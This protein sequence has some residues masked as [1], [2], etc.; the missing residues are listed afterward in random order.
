[1]EFNF[2]EKMK[3]L[4]KKRDLTQE[5]L[6]EYFGVSFQA[7]SK[8]ETNAA[9]PDISLIPIIANFYGVTADEL[10]GVNITKAKKKKE[11]YIQ[12]C[13]D[14]QHEWKLLEAVELARKAC[15]EFPGDLELLENLS[16]WLHQ[17][18]GIT[19]SFLNEAIEISNTILTEST[20]TMIRNTATLRLCYCYNDK[21][22]KGKALE[23]ARQLP[24]FAQSSQ[25]I[26]S[27]L[28]LVPANTQ[29]FIKMYYDAL[30]EVILKYEGDKIEILKNL[31]IMQKII[32]GENMCDQ[33][34]YAYLYN[35]AIACE[36][37]NLNDNDIALDY[38]ETA[39]EHAEK[40]LKYNDGDKYQSTFLKDYESR[41]HSSWSRGAIED[42]L[43]KSND[44]IYDT[45]RDEP[46]F[47]ALLDR[48]K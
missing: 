14:L 23:Y 15:Y 30:A 41:P 19:P 35:T 3:S 9:Y 16:F 31:L 7:V 45:V 18:S 36:Y 6:A 37:L 46:R 1:M 43:D 25:F 33:H 44:S 17:A 29:M 2:G 13:W 47:I 26:I 34:F 10:L 5:Q 27:R 20:D 8:W 42:F 12:S 21:G 24:N 11:E 38:L 28:G 40:F 32:H 39:F 48:A 22:D 4:R